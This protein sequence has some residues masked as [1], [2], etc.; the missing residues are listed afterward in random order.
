MY[1]IRSYYVLTGKQEY[2][3]KAMEQMVAW[4]VTDS[5][6]MAPN[7]NYAQAIKGRFT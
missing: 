3:Q 6:R 2:A 7:M 4:F 5:T 1:A